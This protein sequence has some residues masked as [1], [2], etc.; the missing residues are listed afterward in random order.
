MR[1]CTLFEKGLLH[2]S[3]KTHRLQGIALDFN[4]LVTSNII[5]PSIGKGKVKERSQ[6][7]KWSW[8]FQTPAIQCPTIKAQYRMFQSVFFGF[9]VI[10]YF[11]LSDLHFRELKILYLIAKLISPIFKL[12]TPPIHVPGLPSQLPQKLWYPHKNL[13]SLSLANFLSAVYTDHLHLAH[14]A[15]KKK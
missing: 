12:H 14:N 15:R 13:V 2:G 6:W 4:A 11:F 10:T 9:K 1:L 5:Q 3:G 8:Y 7:W